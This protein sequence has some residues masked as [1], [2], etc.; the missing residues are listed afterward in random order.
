MQIKQIKTEKELKSALAR[1]DEIWSAKKGTKEAKE[2]DL[3]ATLIGDYE[4]NLIVEQRKGQSEIQMDNSD[5]DISI[6][7]SPRTTLLSAEVGVRITHIPTGITVR[8]IE[9][10]TQHLNKLA[11][12]DM[13]KK[14]LNDKLEAV[15]D[16]RELAELLKGSP[17][18]CFAKSEEDLQ[19][20]NMKPVGKEIINDQD[21]S[22]SKT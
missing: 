22:S 14:L 1:I 3:L 5:L 16:T 15:T 2:L 12:L 18:S 6:C 11:A 10:S 20:L 7:R 8:S 21:N 9:Q 4:N 13:L 17:R 19:W